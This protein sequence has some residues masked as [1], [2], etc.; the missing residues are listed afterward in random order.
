MIDFLSARYVASGAM[1]LHLAVVQKPA[2][3]GKSDR[4]EQRFSATRMAACA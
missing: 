1:A 2:E 4:S 3:N